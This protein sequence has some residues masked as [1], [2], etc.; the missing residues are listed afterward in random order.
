VN[1]QE[2]MA[3]DFYELLSVSRDA[4]PEDI[5]RAYR[6]LAL[7]YHPDV[8]KEPGA[9]DHFKELSRAYEVLSDTEQ[10]TRYDRYGEAGLGNGGQG[11]GFAG[12]GFGA[13]DFS[14]IFESFFGG[15][16]GAGSTTS[17]R[18]GGPTR[19]EDLRFDLTLDFKEAVF[20]CEKEINVSHLINCETCRG[21]GTRPGSGPV[22]CRTCTGS[23]QVR[24]ARR[25][26]FGVFTQV[27]ACP[28]CAG[29][30]EVIENPCTTCSGQGRVQKTNAI[31][32]TIPPG[33]DA[34][35]R[36]RVTSE[37]DAGTRGGPRGDLYIYLGIRTHPTFRR[38]GQNI[39]STV[40]ISYLQAILGGEISVETVDG[41]Y[42]LQI[43]PGTQPAT[44]FTLDH[45]GVPRVGN[46]MRRGDHMIEVQ[47]MIP[48]KVSSE[49][50]EHL[51]KLAR[52]RNEKISKK[53]GIEG[54]IDGIGSFFKG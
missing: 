5:K 3:K 6:K 32:V 38:E 43:Q 21:S 33:V 50:R 37:G 2:K 23:G 47:V 13:T 16:T 39:F 8:N 34:G 25:T 28:T 30:G 42:S 7:K 22:S 31:K 18:R 11:D 51:E 17:G 10:R 36:L 19:G 52:I 9:E 20:G 41:S 35:N 49:E 45:K 27:A 1:R 48:T 40:Q 14:D 15:F 4:S 12:S 24:T 26:P 54:I 53:E 44:V 29:R 46:P